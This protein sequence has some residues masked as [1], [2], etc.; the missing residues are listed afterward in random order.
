MVQVTMRLP[1]GLSDGSRRV[2]PCAGTTVG[3][4]LEDCIT[5]EPRLRPRIFRE[6]GDLWVGV[7]LNGRNIRQLQ[8]MET[9]LAEGDEL[10]LL[11]P[12]SGG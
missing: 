7:F 10:R 3:E 11:P 1:I 12:I 8:G 9:E 5:Q 6:N 4:A 2:L